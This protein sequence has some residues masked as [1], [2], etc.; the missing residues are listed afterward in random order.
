MK[1]AP[2]KAEHQHMDRVAALGCMLCYHLGVGGTPAQIHH[3]REGQGMSQRAS[4]YLVIPLCPE[5]HQGRD[6]IHGMGTNAFESTYGVTELGL[7]AMTIE[8]MGA[9]CR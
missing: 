1:R 6:G 5:H 7:L 9:K 2:N 3:L 8:Q 4:N